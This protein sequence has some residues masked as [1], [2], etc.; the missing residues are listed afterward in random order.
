MTAPRLTIHDQLLINLCGWVAVSR[1]LDPNHPMMLEQ[2]ARTI[3]NCSDHPLVEPLAHAAS[4]VVRAAGAPSSPEW[5][6]ARLDLDGALH[7]VFYARAAQAAA[8]IWPEENT[9]PGKEEP[10][11]AAVV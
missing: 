5:L 11:H 4:A 1:F 2:I 7:A 8:Q 9:Q 6:R 10:A 3:P